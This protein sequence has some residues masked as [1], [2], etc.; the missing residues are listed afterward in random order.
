MRTVVEHQAVVAELIERPSPVR[1]PLASARGR[2]LAADT[3]ARHPLPAFD[4]SAMDGY[5]ARS[6]DIASASADHPV[7]LPV[8]ADIPAGRI[9]VPPLAPGTAHRIMT[10]AMMPSGADVI[11]QVEATDGGTDTVRI[12]EPREPRVHVRFSGEDVV[13]GELVLPAGTVLGAAQ[14][15]LLAALGEPTVEVIPPLRVLVMSTGSELVEPGG[16]LAPGQIHESNTTML[17]AAIQGA[18]AQA[19]PVHFVADDVEQFWAALDPLLGD[20]DLVITSG[21]VSAGAYEVVKDALTGQGVE[22]ARVAMQPG[23]PQGAGRLRGVP[24]VTMPGNPVSA[25]VSFEVFVR[26]ALRRAMGYPDPDRPRVPLRLTETIDSPPGKRQFRRGYVDLVGQAVRTI[27]PAGSHFL[28]WLAASDSL[29]DIPAEVTVVEAG[30][31]VDV[32]LLD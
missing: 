30:T 32:W 31:T 1:L 11:V 4:N 22:F 20:A 8:A 13:A 14:L 12:F 6:A 9:D 3:H 2:V 5:A 26:P 23:M 7:E 16:E 29:I 10:G 27:G 24:V 15:G 18:G 21:G 28:R 17:V 19:S 25:L